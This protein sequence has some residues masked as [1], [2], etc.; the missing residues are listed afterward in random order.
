M[1]CSGE[2]TGCPI[3]RKDPLRCLPYKTALEVML[4][5]GNPQ[6]YVINFEIKDKVG[7]KYCNIPLVV[8]HSEVV[9]CI[10][11]YLP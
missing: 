4:D 7:T 8:K 11:E 5:H 1:M 6:E 10:M 3:E 2:G 9:E